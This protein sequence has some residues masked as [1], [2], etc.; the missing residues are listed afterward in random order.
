MGKRARL[1]GFRFFCKAELLGKPEN[2]P[3]E[4]ENGVFS[5]KITN[6]GH[7]RA[8][9]TEALCT[10]SSTVLLDE[11]TTQTDLSTKLRY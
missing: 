11:A 1:P 9:A 2:F 7:T 5:L 8:R 10:R 4:N 6:P 3:T